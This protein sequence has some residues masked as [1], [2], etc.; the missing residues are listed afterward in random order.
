V[1]SPPY[2][3]LQGVWNTRQRGRRGTCKLHRL[4][5]EDIRR[6]SQT[7]GVGTAW[8]RAKVIAPRYP[9]I[10]VEAIVEILRNITWPDLNYRP[11][12]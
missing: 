3:I 4:E 7:C 6:W 9:G 2:G 12:E 10:Q 1:E 5:V 8:Q 11:I